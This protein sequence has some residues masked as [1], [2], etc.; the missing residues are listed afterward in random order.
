MPPP[1]LLKPLPQP[2]SPSLH[3]FAL[4]LTVSVFLNLS[5]A[6]SISHSLFCILC[7]SCTPCLSLGVFLPL[8]VSLSGFLTLSVSVYLCLYLTLAIPSQTLS[9]SSPLHP[10]HHTTLRPA[11]P[12]SGEIPGPGPLCRRGGQ[13]LLNGSRLSPQVGADIFLPPTSPVTS[14]SLPFAIAWP[15]IVHSAGWQFYISAGLKFISGAPV[16][17]HQN[18]TVIFNESW[19]VLSSSMAIGHLRL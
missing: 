1:S 6:V 7:L 2:V 3:L 13:N 9:L 8:S 19:G 10:V 17:D 18:R 15:G 16:S 12:V 11:S 5:L 4:S 14:P